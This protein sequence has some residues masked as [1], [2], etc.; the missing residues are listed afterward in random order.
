[1][2]PENTQ[3]SN[4]QL[5]SNEI[6]KLE[7]AFKNA[8]FRQLLVEYSKEI[9]DP[10]NRRRYEA[11]IKQLELETSGTDCTFLHPQPG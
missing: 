10:E 4:I 1:M 3:N 11:E 7:N 2:A 8:E 6:L 5:T 9:N